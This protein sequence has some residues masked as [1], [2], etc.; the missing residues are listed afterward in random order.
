MVIAAHALGYG[1][2]IVSSPTMS[3]NGDNHDALCEKLGAD[4]AYQAVA[5]L[6]LGHPDTDVDGYS[7]ASVRSDIAEKV[8][9]VK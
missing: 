9:F 6:L 3:L 4:P 8:S 5:V 2:K 7:G 1:T